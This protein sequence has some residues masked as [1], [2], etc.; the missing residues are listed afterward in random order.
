MNLSN[1]NMFPSSKSVLNLCSYITLSLSFM[2]GINSYLGQQDSGNNNF[3]DINNSINNSLDMNRNDSNQ[4][5]EHD[6]EHRQDKLENNQNFDSNYCVS[7]NNNFT[8]TNE[9]KKS[10]VIKNKNRK[11]TFS[12]IC[13]VILVPSRQEY[14]DAGVDLWFDEKMIYNNRKHIQNLLH[15]YLVLHPKIIRKVALSNIIEE[16]DLHKADIS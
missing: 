9:I 2:I 8:S 6:S 1:Y 11:I 14:L 16:I 12:K 4:Q 10:K 3:D 7:D 5:L 13:R 15:N